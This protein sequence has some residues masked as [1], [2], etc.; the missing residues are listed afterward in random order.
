MEDN[1]Q[2]GNRPPFERELFVCDCEDIDHQFVVDYIDDPDWNRVC[3]DVKLNRNLPFW[4]RIGVAFRYLFARK[5]SRFG[6]FDEII[7]KRSDAKRLQ[8]VV[9]AVSFLKEEEEKAIKGE[10]Q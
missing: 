5:P 9:D 4:K 1:Q 7:L 8:K 10:K 6:D 2:N 3:I